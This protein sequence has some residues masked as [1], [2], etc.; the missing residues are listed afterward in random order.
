[1]RG[2]GKTGVSRMYGARGGLLFGTRGGA[3]AGHLPGSR[4][5]DASRRATG[6]RAG[7]QPCGRGTRAVARSRER[8]ACLPGEQDGS[9]RVRNRRDATRRGFP[10][11][12]T[13]ARYRESGHANGDLGAPLRGCRRPAGQGGGDP[14]GVG[15]A[16]GSPGGRRGRT[17]RPARDGRPRAS[18]SRE[19]R[20]RARQGEI[21]RADGATLPLAETVRGLDAPAQGAALA[22]AVAEADGTAVG[23]AVGEALGVAL[24]ETLGEAVGDA[25]GA[26]VSGTVGSGVVAGAFW[27]LF[28]TVSIGA[29]YNGDSRE[30]TSTAIATTNTAL[31]GARTTVSGQS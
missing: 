6:W 26:V 29:S 7:T 25:V 3:C 22:E 23:E 31:T 24:G 21:A 4:A 18:A 20:S 27:G 5:P 1:M 28:V 19:A 11:R 14:G 8:G 12:R 30:D 17:T 2:M 15:S 10:S 13:P 16:G 9:G